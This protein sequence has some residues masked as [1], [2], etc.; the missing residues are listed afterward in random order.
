LRR[1]LDK[2]PNRRLHDIADARIEID[3]VQSGRESEP[4]GPVAAAPAASR[5]RLA[6][7]MAVLTTLIAVAA[8]AWGLR[9]SPPLP[10]V[11]LE[12]TTPPGRN[13]SVAIS[14]DGRTIVFVA[15]SGDQAQLWL[16]P[17]D[18]PT[19]RP[20]AGTE[21][22]TLPFWSPDGRSIGF[23]SDISLKR[24]DIDGGSVKTLSTEAAV[25]IGGTWNR[26]G[27]ILFANN[28]GGPILR[29]SV[30]G[31]DPVAVT[32]IALPQQRGHHSPHFLP[33][34][35]HFLYYVTGTPDARGVYVGE[36]DKPE[37][38][39]LF[40][41][42]TAAVYAATGHLLF[43]REGNLIAQAF[44]PDRL[45]LKGSPFPIADRVTGGTSVSASAA[46]PVI[47]RT[48][49][50]EL[51]QRQLVWVDRSGR[52]TDKVVYQDTAVLGP[53]LSPDG[54][55]IAVYRFANHNM[56]LWTY[57]TRRRAWEKV[58]FDPGDDIWP[59]WS[60]DG[61][62]IIF[63]AVRNHLGA[64]GNVNL[65]RTVLEGAQ[66]GEAL[67]LSTPQAAFPIDLS[68]DGRILLYDTLIPKQGF[69]IWALPLEGGRPST[70]SGRPE[71]A[72]GRKP[73]AV[74]QTEF[75]EGLANF[76]PDGKWIAYQSNKTGR[77]EVYLRPFPGPGADLRVSTEGGAQ[78]RWN[79]KGKELFYIGP[80]DRLMALPIRFSA[81]GKT[82]E[83]GA[84]VGL[85]AT[86]VGSTAT[87]VYRQQYVVSPDGQSFV[88]NS[89][90]G[91]ASASPISVILNWKPNR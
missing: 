20:L 9:G 6:W 7:A 64:E 81:D 89:V 57:D 70:G 85:F 42:D 76:S 62:S 83:F 19:A 54:R 24:T 74:V 91:N 69:D 52:E 41:A 86:N 73:F 75:N 37:G 58:T 82:A 5:L 78:V 33:D 46:G 67:L 35:R 40:G 80:D 32:R 16:R 13:P 48:G 72:Q 31:A 77:S 29:T 3:D 45:E 88:M 43:V 47:Y 50:A 61:T 23:F 49:P 10:E 12:V 15:R 66:Q 14:P 38:T 26:D 39:R 71:P 44:D 4:D 17:L 90:V 65:Y 53:S 56:D 21:R 2:D 34:G 60:R 8:G 79:P 51:G 27:T 25:A 68:P 28:P 63:G 1:C 22:A 59:L 18:S 36:L 84:A 87:N 11:R 55:R 30:D